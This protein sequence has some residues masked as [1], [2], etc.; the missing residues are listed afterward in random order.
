MDEIIGSSNRI[1]EVDLGSRAVN[2][3]QV[4]DEDRRMYLGGKG[5]GLKLLYDRLTPG[6]DPLGE[7]NY[8]AF[9]MGVLLGTGAPC[10]GRFAALTKSPLTG[11]M[12]SSSCGGPFGMAFKTAGY[13]GLLIRGASSEPVILDIDK[14]GV[15]FEDA[16]GLWGKT[17]FETQ[18]ALRANKDDG[19]L[20]IGPAGENKVLYANIVSGHRFLGRGGMGAVMGSKNLKA[21]VAHGKAYAI[22]P[23]NRE[24]FK[25]VSQK[26]TGYINAN[27]TTANLYRNFGT[28]ANTRPC[29]QGG[30][31][32]VNNFRRGSDN[33]VDAV[34]GE[35]MSEKY[36]T[37]YDTCKPC[38]ILCGHKGT[39][40][41]GSSHHI[42]EYESV[43]LLGPNLGIFDSDRITEWNDICC[44]M[45]MDTITAGA[46]LAYV[47]EAGEKGLMQTALRFGS[48]AG[49]SEMLV[50]IARRRGQGNE[51]ADGT[52]RL[53]ERYGGKEFA[54]HVKGLEMAAYDPRGAWGQGLAYAVANRGACHL[55][56]YLVA[57]EIL[58]H[59]LNPYKTYA[60]P[61]FTILF[62]N[63]F[64][65]VNS[66]HTCQFTSYA[67]TLE[68]PLTKYTPDLI[69]GL[70]MQYLPG[71][72]TKLVDF[73]IFA[74][75]FTAVTGIEMT[76]REF[77]E[78]GGRI[79]VLER[80]MNTLEGISRKDDVLPERLLKEGRE[81]DVHKRTVPLDKMLDK[82]YR[83]RGYNDNGIPTDAT[84]KKLGI[85][86]KA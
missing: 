44:Q 47:M 27:R 22:V 52:R 41:D 12:L 26:A 77:L 60:K 2:Y 58:F 34:S 7:D 49:I 25:A 36:Q 39:Y 10:S 35:V 32:P 48:D 84:L 46:T 74:K 69:L 21:I 42:P 75:L 18:D 11:I 68:S 55:S 29:N 81:E 72:A 28:S 19:V 83:L 30:L 8:L 13:D 45:G 62:E 61:E 76:T 66:L 17:T 24:R 40:S 38:T 82:Y 31:I 80:Y 43:Q 79:H 5:L 1:I 65:C 78:A 57:L 54:I 23:K 16:S 3:F 71:I 64:C 63:A 86:A 70:T 53:S 67:Y 9:M 51:L 73:S 59:L 56:A 37:E 15:R 33:R 4:T 14:D 85:V 6:I 20:A 50:D